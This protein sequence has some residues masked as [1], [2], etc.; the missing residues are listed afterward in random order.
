MLRTKEFA[1]P[2]RLSTRSRTRSRLRD[3]ARRRND[4]FQPRVEHLE[5]RELL[6]MAGWSI[7]MGDAQ[8]PEFGQDTAVHTDAS[9][10][11]FLYVTGKYKGTVD[12]DPD[13]N[14]TYNL[15]SLGTNEDAFVA[16]YETPTGGDP[17]LQWAVS[18]GTAENIE[19]GELITV[20]ASGNAT[21]V[22]SGYDEIVHLDGQP[23]RP[24]WEQEIISGR[25]N[26]VTVDGAENIYLQGHFRKPPISAT[27]KI[28][29]RSA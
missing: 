1:G 26:D 20:D 12:F 10:N 14:V 28:R 9:G 11:Q 6:T 4:F 16:K 29:R 15:T 3:R 5:R 21:A 22:F 7:G 24:F 13:P 2:T 18:F 19:L 27:P 25:A 17:V 8:S 23:A